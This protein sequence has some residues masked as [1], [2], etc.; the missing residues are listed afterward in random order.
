MT[1]G[2]FAWNDLLRRPRERRRPDPPRAVFVEG[3]PVA[4]MD[5]GEDDWVWTV[6]RAVRDTIPK[7]YLTFVLGPT[8]PVRRAGIDDYAKPVLDVVSP[9]ARSVWVKLTDGET[10]GVK[11]GNVAPPFPPRIDRSIEVPFSSDRDDVREMKEMLARTPPMAGASDVG[12]HLSFGR[13]NVGDFD[14]GGPVRVMFDA[15]SPVLDGTQTN[16]GDLRIKDLRVTR[17]QGRID[18]CEI[19]IWAFDT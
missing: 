12:V 10:A 19:R 4:W 14:F 1:Y 2:D 5:L 9:H 6:S 13:V 18:G 8:R 16:P 3:D 17:D 11:I 15:L 7:P